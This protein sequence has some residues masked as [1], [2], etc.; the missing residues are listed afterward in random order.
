MLDYLY[1]CKESHSTIR[2]PRFYTIF[3]KAKYKSMA[4]IKSIL[5]LNL[6]QSQSLLQSKGLE[7]LSKGGKEVIEIRE[8]E[9]ADMI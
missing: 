1:D 4:L 9:P 6:D 2:H 5:D 8:V 3:P 7:A